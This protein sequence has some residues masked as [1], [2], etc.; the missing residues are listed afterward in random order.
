MQEEYNS[1]WGP[2]SQAVSFRPAALG[3]R[4][5]WL[6]LVGLLTDLLDIQLSSSTSCHHYN[7]VLT[8]S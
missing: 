5:I 6:T 1:G 8:T 7:N 2:Q 4:L 3:A